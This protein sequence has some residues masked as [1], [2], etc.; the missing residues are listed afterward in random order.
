V[1][2]GILGPGRRYWADAQFAIDWDAEQATCPQGKPSVAWTLADDA[3]G[4]PIVLIRFGLAACRACPVL[5][6]CVASSRE[7]VLRLRRR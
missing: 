7:R 6:Q 5:S 2:A 4:H 3:D 1:L